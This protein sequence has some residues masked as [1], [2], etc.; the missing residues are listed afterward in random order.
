MILGVLLVVVALAGAG[1]VADVEATAPP[2]TEPP[3]TANDFFPEQRDVTDCIGVLERPGCGSESRGGW[4]QTLVF[5]LI[6][7]GLIVVFTKIV[8][9]VQRGR[10]RDPDDPPA[11]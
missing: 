10:T 1:R 4:R 11:S 5:G 2:S 7:A 8:I 9:G 3:V 6:A